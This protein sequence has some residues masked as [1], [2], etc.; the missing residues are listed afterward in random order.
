MNLKKIIV[1]ALAVVIVAGGM[2]A[3][4]QFA[5]PNE[6]M[7]GI[8]ADADL[9]ADSLVREFEVHYN[10]ANSKYL[11]KVISVRGMITEMDYPGAIIVLGGPGKPSSVRCYMDSA[12]LLPARQ[13]KQG[14]QV[15]IKGSCTGFN[16]DELLGS[17]VILHRCVVSRQEP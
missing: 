13:L 17:D 3:Y 12:E 8:K 15:S 1:P 9:T 11:G 14:M 7:Q 2:Y 6:S 4:R 10:A 16:T 5:R